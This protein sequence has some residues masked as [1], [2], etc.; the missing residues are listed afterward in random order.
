MLHL[1]SNSEDDR[2]NMARVDTSLLKFGYENLIDMEFNSLSK[3]SRHDS[4][5]SELPS[6]NFTL[7]IE[8]FYSK[9]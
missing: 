5:C 9:K 6:D 3:M 1:H 2:P 4:V 7:C 8:N